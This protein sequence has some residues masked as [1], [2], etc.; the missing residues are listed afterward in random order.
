MATSLIN[1]ILM[2]ALINSFLAEAGGRWK[3]L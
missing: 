1:D 3:S 2:P